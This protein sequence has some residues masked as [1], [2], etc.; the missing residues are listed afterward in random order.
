MKRNRKNKV[1]QWEY[2]ALI[3][4]DNFFSCREF[5]P[6]YIWIAPSPFLATY[7]DI[8][9]YGFSCSVDL[10]IFR[11][12]SHRTLS[13][14]FSV[15]LPWKE[16]RDMCSCTER[17]TTAGHTPTISASL[18]SLL[19]HTSKSTFI[20]IYRKCRNFYFSSNGS[21]ATVWSSFTLPT[22]LLGNQSL[23]ASPTAIR[24][25]SRYSRLISGIEIKETFSIF[26]VYLRDKSK[27]E[28][29]NRR[30]INEAWILLPIYTYIFWS[31][32]SLC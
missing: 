13:T 9:L 14:L 26:E 2:Q 15:K 4:A 32:D 19:S 31:F 16:R 20:Y 11:N 22:S 23:R 27:K 5:S 6:I 12:V 18:Q 3:F 8:N 24:L 1:K 28:K 7:A 10:E 29:F 30:K 17:N 25:F 21:V